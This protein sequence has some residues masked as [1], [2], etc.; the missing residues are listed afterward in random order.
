MHISIRTLKAQCSFPIFNVR[1]GYI[2]IGDAASP[3][4]RHIC[5]PMSCRLCSLPWTG[6][7]PIRVN[8]VIHALK[9][10]LKISLPLQVA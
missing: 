6:R 10:R 8:G 7:S 9:E 2:H 3:R 4:E 1:F 5:R